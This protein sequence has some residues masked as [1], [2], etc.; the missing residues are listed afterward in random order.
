MVYGRDATVTTVR[1]LAPTQ[2]EVAV[3]CLSAACFRLKRK[4]EGREEKRRSN[5]LEM[6][7]EGRKVK[8]KMEAGMEGRKE[9]ERKE[10][11][12][13]NGR[14]RG[15]KDGEGWKRRQKEGMEGKGN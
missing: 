1:K 12:A 7:Y 10:K 13:R 8:E 11:E 5:N 9:V 14:L 2:R 3:T 4:M 6:E 15:R